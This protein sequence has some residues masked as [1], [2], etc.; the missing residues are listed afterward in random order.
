MEA[1][2][3]GGVCDKASLQISSPKI[4]LNHGVRVSI[5]GSPRGEHRSNADVHS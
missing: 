3:G 1:D 2:G 5:R 4:P